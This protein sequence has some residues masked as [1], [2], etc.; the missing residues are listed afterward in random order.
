LNVLTFEGLVVTL[1]LHFAGVRFLFIEHIGGIILELHLE[2]LEDEAF[3]L[4]EAKLPY[5][6]PSC[7]PLFA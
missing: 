5:L 2:K 6:P 7:F 3:G 4:I 1:I